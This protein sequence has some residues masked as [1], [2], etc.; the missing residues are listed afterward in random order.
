MVTD[1]RKPTSLSLNFLTGSLIRTDI[2]LR[3]TEPKLDIL[4]ITD[5]EDIVKIITRMSVV[6]VT[7]RQKVFLRTEGKGITS[8]RDIPENVRVLFLSIRDE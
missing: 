2:V 1:T 5:R 8:K 7:F 3:G 6:S 4:V